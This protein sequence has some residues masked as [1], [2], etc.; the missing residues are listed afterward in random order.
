MKNYS[1]EQIEKNEAGGVRSIRG[2]EERCIHGFGGGKEGKR[3]FGSSRRRWENNIKLV[4]QE[5]GRGSW[6]RSI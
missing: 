1:G 5:M 6:T 3:P 4:F 2:R